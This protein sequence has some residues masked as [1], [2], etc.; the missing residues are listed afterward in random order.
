MQIETHPTAPESLFDYSLIKTI[1]YSSD[2]IT[3]LY[4]S[5][6]TGRKVFIKLISKSL[7][8]DAYSIRQFAHKLEILKSLYHP[9]LLACD[10]YHEDLNYFY[11]MN[12]YCQRGD[13]AKFILTNGAFSETVAKN[14]LRQLASAI[15]FLHG[16]NIAHRDVM[17]ENVLLDN[18]LNA[19]LTNLNYCCLLDDKIHSTMRLHSSLLY[20]A[21]ELLEDNEPIDPT[22][23]D[24]WALGVILFTMVSGKLPWSYTSTE[25]IQDQ[26][27]N[28]HYMFPISFSIELCDL[29]QH[30]LTKDPNDRF[31]T[32]QV[33]THIWMKK[34]RRSSYSTEKSQGAQTSRL[35]AV[36]N[37]TLPKLPVPQANVSP[38]ILKIGSL[39]PKKRRILSTARKWPSMII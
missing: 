15:G 23:C 24:M 39:S 14:I 34:T 20:A 3:G 32:D 8:E 28:C 18:E 26:I 12:K 30:L 21:P 29:I 4:E 5:N 2:T 37:S 10:E 38:T 1:N 22:K 25:S 31:N 27:Q 11:V 19:I 36:T 33:L 6:K 16:N 13:L 7:F 17:L 9:S 35:P